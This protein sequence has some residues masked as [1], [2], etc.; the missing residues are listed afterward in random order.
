[1]G[2]K[3]KVRLFHYTISNQGG[4]I[5][6]TLPFSHGPTKHSLKDV[7]NAFE[8]HSNLKKN[9]TVE[10][11]K[12]FT[13]VQEGELL[14]EFIIDL[15]ILASTCNFSTLWESLV[16]DQIICGIHDSKLRGDL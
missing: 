1:M 4:E 2:E 10:R 15:K 5:H 8:T 13:R 3:K 11:Y 9:K 7:I 6:G 12:F 14:K 16:H